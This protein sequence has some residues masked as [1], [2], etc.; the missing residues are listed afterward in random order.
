MTCIN[1]PLAA[2]GFHRTT[3]CTRLV[4]VRDEA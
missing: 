4:R 3:G 1:S 2:R